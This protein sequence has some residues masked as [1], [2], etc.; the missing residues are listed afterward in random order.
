MNIEAMT[1][2]AKKVGHYEQMF[3]ARRDERIGKFIPLVDSDA[4]TARLKEEMRKPQR[5]MHRIKEIIGSMQRT[6]EVISEYNKLDIRGGL[7]TSSPFP[8]LPKIQKFDE[9]G[10]PTGE[11]S[12]GEVGDDFEN[13]SG[14]QL[15]QWASLGPEHVARSAESQAR[16][17]KYMAERYLDS[18]GNIRPE[19]AREYLNLIRLNADW[20]DGLRNVKTTGA[21]YVGRL[22]ILDTSALKEEAEVAFQVHQGVAGA[23]ARLA[24]IQAARKA[25]VVPPVSASGPGTPPPPPPPP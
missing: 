3:G 20:I 21:P 10:K 8:W 5:D 24:T 25:K 6:S 15:A 22:G 17:I 4:A 13:L 14:M 19:S 7:R 23:A 9:D 11:W 18:E 12:M 2:G 16:I 1:D